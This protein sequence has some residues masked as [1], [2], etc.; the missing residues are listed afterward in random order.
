MATPTTS[1]AKCPRSLAGPRVPSSSSPPPTPRRSRDARGRPHAEPRPS[2]RERHHHHPAKGALMT[3][4]TQDTSR[5]ARLLALMKKGD[6]AI[7]TRDW[8]GADQVYHPDMELGRG[9]CRE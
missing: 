7:N 6:D 8:T 3:I 4:P 9:P 1:P 2:G 5:T